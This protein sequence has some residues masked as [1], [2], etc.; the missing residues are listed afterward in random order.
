MEMRLFAIGCDTD[1]RESECGYVYVPLADP[2]GL[3]DPPCPQDFLFKIMQ[4][5]FNF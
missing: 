3:W 1:T 2:G 4:F 5:S